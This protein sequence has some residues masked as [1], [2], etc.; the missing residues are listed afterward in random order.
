MPLS[1]VMV[2][3]TE[4]LRMLILCTSNTKAL[5]LRAHHPSDVNPWTLMSAT[6]ACSGTCSC[7]CKCCL[8]FPKSQQAGVCT[9]LT[10]TYDLQRCTP[11]GKE[12]HDFGVSN[13]EPWT[14]NNLSPSKRLAI[15]HQTT[16]NPDP[17]LCS[18][19]GHPQ[20]DVM[21]CFDAGQPRTP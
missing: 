5:A 9:S 3:G 15:E 2:T 4:K 12:E 10:E 21:L 19:V 1:R 18:G 13:T 11:G 16:S 20:S 14:P 17:H 6:G 7:V 8:A